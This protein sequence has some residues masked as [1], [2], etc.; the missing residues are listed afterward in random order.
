[1]TRRATV[2]VS[3]APGAGKT[4]LARPLAEALGFALLSKDDIKE[5]L[6]DALALPVGDL[7]WSRR[8]GGASMELL[9][10]LASR[11]PQVVLEAP[12]RPHGPNERLRFPGLAR[13]IVE[14][15]CECP[16][17]ICAQRY[18]QRSAHSHATHVIKSLSPEMLAEFNGP[19]GVGPVIPVDTTRPVDI[20]ALTTT[21]QA[22][23]RHEGQSPV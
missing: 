12:F 2:L 20:P 1:M 9:W 3:G 5:T 7:A 22:F 4:T 14:V 8:I 23:L 11:C 19:V 15:Y 16:P 10:A 6:H 21:V 17:A 13:P 18:A